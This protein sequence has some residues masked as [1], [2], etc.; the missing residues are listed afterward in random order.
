MAPAVLAALRPSA[1][2]AGRTSGRPCSGAEWLATFVQTNRE[3]QAASIATSA[4]GLL[5]GARAPE[6]ALLAERSKDCEAKA[7][8]E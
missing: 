3:R 4:V 7:S 1:A 6:P 2:A 8:I 5:G